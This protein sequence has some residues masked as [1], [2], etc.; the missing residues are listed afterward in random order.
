MVT[1]KQAV[2]SVKTFKISLRRANLLLFATMTLV[3][4]LIA[5]EQYRFLKGQF[6]T[7]LEKTI[8]GNT[9]QLQDYFQNRLD[10]LHYVFNKTAQLDLQKLKEAQ[11]YF[12]TLDKPLEPIYKKLNQNVVFGTYD[13]YLVD[14]DKVI[15]RSTFAP[16]VGM[17]FKQYDYASRI[18]DMVRDKVIPYYVSPPYFSTFTQDFRKSFLTL[19]R[20][21]KFFVQISHNYYL[22]ENV[23]K[24]LG[25]LKRCYPTSSGSTPS[26][27]AT[28]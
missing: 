21:G 24:D 10:K 13:I 26:F 22:L 19:S 16:D 23:K 11:D 27:R 17:D 18:F 12:D 1:T 4:V 3:V 8:E 14:L 9:Y 2:E 20:N 28:S 25:A 6:S 7:E 5:A 15:V